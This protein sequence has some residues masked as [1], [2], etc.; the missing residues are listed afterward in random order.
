MTVNRQ[1]CALPPGPTYPSPCTA[2]HRCVSPPQIG[3]DGL[4][5]LTPD[6]QRTL[7]KFPLEHVSRWAR[8]GNM[9]NLYTRTPTDLEE[10]TVTLQGDDRTIGSVLD[11][12]TSSCMQCVAFSERQASQFS[13]SASP[14]SRQWATGPCVAHLTQQSGVRRMVELLKTSDISTDRDQEVAEALSALLNGNGNKKRAS[15]RAH[16]PRLPAR[17]SP[18]DLMNASVVVSRLP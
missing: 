5:L 3:L 18:S 8:R 11:T 1:M 2:T 6:T 15:V 9:L 4:F 16:H 10:R 14:A 13:R 7:R 17:F 12:L